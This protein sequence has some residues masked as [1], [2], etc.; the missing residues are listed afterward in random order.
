L[1]FANTVLLVMGNMGTPKEFT[2]SW[3]AEAQTNRLI[4]AQN[5]APLNLI[6]TELEKQ[7]ILV[8]LISLLNN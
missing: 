2:M 1:A 6:K 3:F 5:M 8:V 7:L 4:L